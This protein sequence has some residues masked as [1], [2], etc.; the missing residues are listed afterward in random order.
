MTDK[1]HIEFPTR[2]EKDGTKSILVA[3]RMYIRNAKEIRGD[4]YGDYNG[5]PCCVTTINGELTVIVIRKV[6]S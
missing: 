2:L 3:G 1:E 5:D 4:I 6:E